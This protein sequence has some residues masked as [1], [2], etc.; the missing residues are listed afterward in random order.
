MGIL[1]IRVR[2]PELMVLLNIKGTPLV[3]QTPSDMSIKGTR[4]RYAELV[5]FLTFHCRYELTYFTKILNASVAFRFLTQ[6]L[7]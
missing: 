5:T 2:Y 1:E 4:V 7:T 3:Y 6:N